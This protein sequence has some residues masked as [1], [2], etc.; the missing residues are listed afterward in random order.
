[1]TFLGFLRFMA[2]WF[3]LIIILMLLFN[4]YKIV[5]GSQEKR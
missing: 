2:A 4:Y 1:M 3:I 5:Y